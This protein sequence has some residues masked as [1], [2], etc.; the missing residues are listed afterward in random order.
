MSGLNAAASVATTLIQLC[1]QQSRAWHYS[2]VDQSPNADIDIVGLMSVV[3]MAFAVLCRYVLLGDNVHV[4]VVGRLHCSRSQ[5]SSSQS[6]HSRHAS[7]G[8]F[9]YRLINNTLLYYAFRGSENNPL[10]VCKLLQMLSDFQSSFTDTLCDKF[11]KQVRVCYGSGT[12]AHI[13]QAS[14]VTRARRSSGQPADCAPCA[15]ASG[16]K[17][18]GCRLE[19]VTSYQ[20]LHSLSID[21]YLLEE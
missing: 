9:N 19:S 11:A 18:H 1:D 6:R 12:V 13:Q 2:I 15:A 7:L 4:F 20:K 14:D 3:M 10:K 21:A 17:R 5:L 8:L 16:S